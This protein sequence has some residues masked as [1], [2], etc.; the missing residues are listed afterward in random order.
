[1][2]AGSLTNDRDRETIERACG[3]LDRSAAAF[4]PSLS[5]GEAIIVGPDVPAPLPIMMSVPEKGQRPESHGP[6]YQMC[7]GREQAGDVID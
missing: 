5:Q 7:W 2:I 1:M 3:D 4:I 6:N